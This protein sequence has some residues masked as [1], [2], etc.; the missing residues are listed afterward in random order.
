MAADAGDVGDV[1][2]MVLLDYRAASDTV[3][4]TILLNRLRTSHHIGGIILEL[5][6]NY[7]RERYPSVM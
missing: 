7:L 1:S 3:D 4:H 2:V 6:E 5:L